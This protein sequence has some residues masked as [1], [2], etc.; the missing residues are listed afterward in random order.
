MMFRRVIE[1]NKKIKDKRSIR[2]NGSKGVDNTFGL[3]R[4]MILLSSHMLAGIDIQWIFAPFLISKY[5]ARY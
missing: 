2:P 5:K 4:L 1:R 3:Y